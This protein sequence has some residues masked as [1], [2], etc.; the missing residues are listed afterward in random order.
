MTAL[1]RTSNN[2]KRQPRPL[3]REGAPNH[4]TR[5]CQT[6]IKIWSY[7]PDGCFIPGLTGSLTVGR[8]IRLKTQTQPSVQKLSKKKENTTEGGRRRRS[9]SAANQRFLESE[10]ELLREGFGIQKELSVWTVIIECNCDSDVKWIQSSN[11]ESTII[12][13][14]SPD[15]R[16]NSKNR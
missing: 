12:S 7:A 6:I 4:Q 1:A 3:M 8:N 10:A 5:N 15:T 14:V 16:D 13:H 11:L 9:D 2:C